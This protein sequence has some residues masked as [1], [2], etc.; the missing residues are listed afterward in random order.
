VLAWA[1][2]NSVK[3][4]VLEEKKQRSEIIRRALDM[5]ALTIDG[6]PAA[7]TTIARKRAVFYGT[8][9][10]AVEL[11]LL[12]ANPIDKVSWR[13]AKVAD[14]VD[15]RVVAS[16]AQVRALL[17]AVETDQPVLTAF[18]GCLY[19]AYMRPG[20]AVYLRRWTA[21]TFPAPDGENCCS[22]ATRRTQGR[23]GQTPGQRATNGNSSTVRKRPPGPC[24]YRQNWSS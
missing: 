8:L 5:L 3:V 7:A 23:N 13:A 9:K 21:L 20:E 15:R 10:Y 16:P 14:Q 2:D 11:D 19:Y 17:A 6:R 1:R 4:L 12:A 24:R 22:P 18:F